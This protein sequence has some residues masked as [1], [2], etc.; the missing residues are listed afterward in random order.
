MEH[1]CMLGDV[2]RLSL[3]EHVLGRVWLCVSFGA[4]S[5]SC[6]SDSMAPA[7]C[8]LMV[9]CCHYLVHQQP[10]LWVVPEGAATSSS[11]GLHTY[12]GGR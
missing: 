5:I 6:D 1:A 4:G 12:H 2:S 9:L 7:T 10:A 11:L 3:R 8:W